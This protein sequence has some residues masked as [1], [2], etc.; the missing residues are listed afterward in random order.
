MQVAGIEP[1]GIARLGQEPLRLRGIVGVGLEGKGEVEFAWDHAPRE[2]GGPE[3]LR[4][5]QR[6]G[7]DGVDRGQ[8]HP[9]I[10]P[11]RLGVPLVEEVQVEGPDP[12][13]ERQLQRRI[14]PHL[15]RLRRI[16]EVREIDLAALQH[17]EPR[18]GLGDALVDQPFD[19]GHLAPVALEGLHD[20]L[21]ARRMAHE[22]VRPEADGVLLEAV[23]PD[24]LDIFLRHDPARPG[25]EGPIEGHEVRPRLVQLEAHPV[26]ADD[27]HL[28]HLVVEDLGPGAREAELDVLGRERIAVVKREPLAQLELV[29]ALIGA[30]RPRFRQASR[31]EAA[32]HGLH[33]RIVQGIDHPE[34]RD[35]AHDLGRIEPDRGERHVQRPAHL[36]LGPGL[37]GSFVGETGGERGAHQEHTAQ[38]T[39]PFAVHARLPR[40]RGRVG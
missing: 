6:S 32:G 2:A 16:Q 8:P 26:G 19:V 35:D 7:V 20:Q 37:R 29:D 21:D 27:R 40:F 10:V 30:H 15:L 39:T 4:V 12:A 25:R 38:T 22:L 1:V 34:G 14:S 11:G 31:H 9:P 33:E 36:S 3:V 5:V 24:V 28:P 17:G 23:V 13:G 18:G